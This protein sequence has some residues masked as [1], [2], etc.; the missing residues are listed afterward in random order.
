MNSKKN[1]T[2]R[3]N[4]EDFMRK[5]EFKKILLGGLKKLPA[6]ERAKASEFYDE[7]YLDGTEAGLS[8][9]DVVA[10][11][12]PPEEAAQKILND[13]GASDDY[14]PQNYGENDYGS[15]D[16]AANGCGSKDY[17]SRNRKSKAVNQRIAKSKSYGFTRRK[18]TNT[19]I[20]DLKNH[21]EKNG[22]AAF[23]P[24][25]E[26]RRKSIFKSKTFWTIYLAGFVITVPLTAGLLGAA[27]G[28]AAGLLGAAI[29]IAAGLLGAAVSLFATAL[30][31]IAGGVVGIGYGI[32]FLFTDPAVGLLVVG[33]SML[34]LGFGILCFLLTIS[35]FK[36]VKRG[37]S[38]KKR[39]K[40]TVF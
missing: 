2:A 20:A 22:S 15:Q 39:K 16:C 38:G 37:L 5:S 34:V 21:A 31:L 6:S 29:G 10:Q 12:G 36:A 40:E 23:V 11:W 35:V 30:G 27:I 1:N 8:E 18:I 25:A 7:L 9:E 26:K 3:K 24:P 4:S 33:E 13:G 19:E 17:E 28:I 32:F 14:E